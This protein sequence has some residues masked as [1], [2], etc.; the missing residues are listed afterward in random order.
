MLVLET[1]RPPTP[2]QA[3]AFDQPSKA[4][5]KNLAFFVKNHHYGQQEESGRGLGLSRQACTFIYKLANR[6]V[7]CTGKM[8]SHPLTLLT[9]QIHSN[10][11]LQCPSA[12]LD[13]SDTFKHT[14]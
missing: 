1:G 9:D 12:L 5:D 3:V 13:Q 2:I 10:I 7:H 8:S 4:M 14:P 6:A 11:T